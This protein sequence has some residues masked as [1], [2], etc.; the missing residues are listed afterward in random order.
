MMELPIALQTRDDLDDILIQA[1]QMNASDVH[2]SSD[3]RL[4][5]RQHGVIQP[6]SLRTITMTELSNLLVASQDENTSVLSIV[7]SGEDLDFAYV[8]KKPFN[9]EYC[10]FRVNASSKQANGKNG[11]SIVF[12]A[13]NPHPPCVEDLGVEDDIIDCMTN[14]TK[15]L[16]IVAGPTGSGKSTLLA[17]INRK[18]LETRS[19]V[20]ITHESP[21]EFV[22]DEVETDSVVNQREIGHSGNYKTFYDALVGALRQD[23]DLILVGEARD[24]ET[25]NAAIHGVQTGHALFTTVHTQG[26]AQTINRIVKE[27]ESHEREAKLM[28]I[29]DSMA[30]I[31]YQNLVPSVDGKRVALREYLIFDGEVKD[32]LRE[33]PINALFTNTYSALIDKGQT[34]LMD[35]KKHLESGRIDKNIYR[36]IE[37]QFEADISKIGLNKTHKGTLS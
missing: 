27:F 16:A 22:Y 31:V 18:R 32:R 17:A 13:I 2:F 9:D 6:V 23:P 4:S 8:C 14:L 33:S 26:V 11:L 12:R 21:I 29:I 35:A 1:V 15:G 25:I 19:E 24:R 20:M 37:K 5:V 30:I 3:L 7:N 28:D 10:R 36:K 34:L